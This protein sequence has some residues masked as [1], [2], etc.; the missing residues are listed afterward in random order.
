MRA[1]LIANGH[2]TAHNIGNFLHL[3][4]SSFRRQVP[5]VPGPTAGQAQ[6]VFL[7]GNVERADH[8]VAYCE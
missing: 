8:S 3:T 1:G 2:F 4:K 7:K 5:C 6:R